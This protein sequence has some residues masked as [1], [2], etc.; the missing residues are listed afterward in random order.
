[1]WLQAMREERALVSGAFAVQAVLVGCLFSYGVFVP[2]IEAEMGWS[3]TWMSAC[4]TFVVILMGGLAFPTGT[5][6]DRFGSLWL[7]RLA[8]VLTA[9]GFC[10]MGTMSEPWH[11]MLGYAL[12]VGLALSAHDVGTLSPIAKRF[13]AHR[14]VMTGIVKTG[15][16]LGQTVVPAIVAAL[17]LSVG[18]RNAAFVLALAALVLVMFAAQGVGREA[19]ASVHANANGPTTGLS[20]AQARRTRTLWTFCAV[21]FGFFPALMTVPVHLVSHGLELGMGAQQ[22]A[23][24]LSTIGAF[25]AVGRLSVGF[26][27]D[28]LGAKGCLLLC[29]SVL[30]FALLALRSI[31]EASYLYVFGAAYGFAHGGLFTAVSP[32]V[33]AIFGMRSHAS[34]LGIILMC[35]TVSGAGLQYMAGVWHDSDGDYS[36][37]FS[38]IA[39]MA[40]LSLLCAATLPKQVLHV[41]SKTTS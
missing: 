21:Q 10:V 38:V 37:A 3:R 20:L 41:E 32:S 18:W 15:T 14:G 5:L 4:S 7:L 26:L 29:L 33:A 11:L 30:V 23:L 6:V 12:L 36:R 17:I 31:S 2:A 16:A 24:T 25:S 22:A 13:P 28:R 27:F 1:M 34:L 9:L 40:M 19:K 39:A 35:G 8:A